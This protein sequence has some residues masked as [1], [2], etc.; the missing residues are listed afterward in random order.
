MWRV[1]FRLEQSHRI[2]SLQSF[3]APV[4]FENRPE[5]AMVDSNGRRQSRGFEQEAMSTDPTD[6]RERGHPRLERGGKA[7]PQSQDCLLVTPK[8]LSGCGTEVMNNKSLQ[9]NIGNINA[10][11]QTHSLCSIGPDCHELPLRKHIKVH[12]ERRLLPGR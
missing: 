2:S 6:W 7:D 4:A 8:T 11:V 5:N 1:V 9:R 10:E 3:F 12:G